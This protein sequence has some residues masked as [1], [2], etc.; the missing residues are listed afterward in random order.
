MLSLKNYPEKSV[1]IDVYYVVETRTY[2]FTNLYFQNLLFPKLAFFRYFYVPG[3]RWIEVV[4]W[5][6]VLLRECF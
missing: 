6:I 1:L 5:V 4:F 3:L 2:F